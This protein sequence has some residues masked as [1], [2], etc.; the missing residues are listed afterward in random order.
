[1]KRAPRTEAVKCGFTICEFCPPK[2]DKDDILLES[3]V[4]RR[5]RPPLVSPDVELEG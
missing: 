3:V 1:M 4:K 2:L 5:W